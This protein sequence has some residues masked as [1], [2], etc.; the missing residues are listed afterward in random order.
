MKL[1]LTIWCVLVAST[2]YAQTPTLVL[3]KTITFDVDTTT[4]N[5]KL[6]DGV[7]AVTQAI[8]FDAVGMNGNGAVAVSYVLP[9]KPPADVQGHVGPVSI[10]QGLITASMDKAY[11]W[12]LTLI[13]PGGTAV[14]NAALPFVL[15][16]MPAPK[17]ASNL[18]IQ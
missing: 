6:S 8:Q 12:K 16:T 1:L 9:S 5:G 15:A 10:A 3:N 14:A 2:V 11:T 7:T 18:A 17:A 13:G 4:Y